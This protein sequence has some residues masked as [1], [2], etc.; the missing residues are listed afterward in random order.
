MGRSFWKNRFL[1]TLAVGFAYVA[2]LSPALA[3]D[4]CD[5]VAD[6][7]GWTD[8]VRREEI[9]SDARLNL[10]YKKIMDRLRGDA[11][12]TNRVR[13]AQRRWIA[14]RDAQCELEGFATTGGSVHST[15]V[16]GCLERL[17]TQ[18]AGELFYMLTCQE[19][20]LTCLNPLNPNAVSQAVG[21]NRAERPQGASSPGIVFESPDVIEKLKVSG[22]WFPDQVKPY[23]GLSG[24]AIFVFSNVE[25]GETFSAAVNGVALLPEDYWKNK[26]VTDPDGSDVAALADKV[27]ASGVL[28]IRL[29]PQTRAKIV[30]CGSRSGNSDQAASNVEKCLRLGSAVVDIQDV[31]FDGNKE[32][33]FRQ[34]GE[35][36]RGVDAYE[37][38]ELPYDKYL[39]G[40]KL[41]MPLS[42]LDQMAEINLSKRQI[43]LGTSSGACSSGSTIYGVNPKYGSGL[44]LIGRE[45][46]SYNAQ[47]GVCYVEHY[48]AKE[49]QSGDGYVLKLV[50]RTPVQ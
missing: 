15:I 39:A 40:S 35:S 19:G 23:V 43:I 31:D 26:G 17:T 4:K 27:R 25:T 11:D 6:Y 13:E 42:E 18:R 30:N 47:S 5:G 10:V 8:C 45:Q 44:I 20:D 33:V 9:S 29:S 28:E 7:S 16:S 41:G 24:A 12:A 14:F 22:V 46:Y 37:V 32:F 34:A 50:S 36:Q 3:A 38:L 1:E 2:V 21:A 48:E 49:Q